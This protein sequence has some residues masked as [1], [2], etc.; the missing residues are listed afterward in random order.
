MSSLGMGVRIF[1]E[2]WAILTFLPTRGRSS[3]RTSSGF[4]GVSH[5]G[6]GGDECGDIGP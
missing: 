3:K 5:R 1:R 6:T 2:I 4:I